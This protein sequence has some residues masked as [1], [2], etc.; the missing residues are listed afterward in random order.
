MI[1]PGMASEDRRFIVATLYDVSEP[2][3]YTAY[4]EVIDPTTKKWVR[5]KA[6]KFEVEPV[7]Q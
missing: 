6:V 2:G 1:W 4:V 3:K 7:A 5:T